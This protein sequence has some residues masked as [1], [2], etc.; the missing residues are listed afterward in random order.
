MVEG[1]AA[2]PLTGY[3]LL[4]SKAV[5]ATADFSLAVFA[6]NYVIVEFDGTICVS[7]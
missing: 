3:I 6:W 2:L 5:T 7:G 1:K 4:S